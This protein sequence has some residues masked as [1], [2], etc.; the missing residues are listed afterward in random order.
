MIWLA[1]SHCE[2]A[3]RILGFAIQ[4]HIIKKQWESGLQVAN[5]NYQFPPLSSAR[6][7]S[8]IT[9]QMGALMLFL[10]YLSWHFWLQVME[11]PTRWLKP[12]EDLL[13]HIKVSL[14]RAL[15][16]SSG[17]YLHSGFMLRQAFS[18]KHQGWRPA[19]LGWYPPSLLT[20]AD[21]DASFPISPKS[22]RLTASGATLGLTSRASRHSLENG[23]LWL[24]R[25]WSPDNI[26]PALRSCSLTTSDLLSSWFLS[27][28]LSYGLGRILP[29]SWLLNFVVI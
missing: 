14:I 4:P 25:S 10:Q 15:T 6:S 27:V 9:C 13:D 26:D 8:F 12:K 29:G 19:A 1:L 2:V 22:P 5:S 11:K 18:W 28:F 7:L 20:P 21:E 23:V 3:S 17:L 24:V 16:M